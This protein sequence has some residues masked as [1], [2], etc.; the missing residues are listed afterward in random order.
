MPCG[1]ATRFA[2]RA[3]NTLGATPVAARTSTNVI[4][5]RSGSNDSARFRLK[6]IMRANNFTNFFKASLGVYRVSLSTRPNQLNVRFRT[7]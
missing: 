1:H 2:P 6:W 3:A 7:D 5:R 4:W